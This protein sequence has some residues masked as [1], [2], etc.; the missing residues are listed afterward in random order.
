MGTLRNLE[1][2]YDIVL[3]RKYVEWYKHG[4]HKVK[5][6][7]GTDVDFPRLSELQVWAQELLEEDNSNFKL[8]QKSFVFLMHQGY[9]FMYFV[10]DGNENPAVWHYYEGNLEPAVK[11]RSFSEYMRDT[12]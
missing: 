12:Q 4:G 9:Q 5:S 1:K 10:C 8:P 11:W 2:K 3:P 7:I 6:L